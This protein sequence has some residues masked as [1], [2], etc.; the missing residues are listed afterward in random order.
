MAWATYQIIYWS[1]SKLEFMED[2]EEKEEELKR[3]E[4]EL[5]FALKEK[6]TEATAAAFGADIV[7]EG[8]G[9]SA[10]GRNWWNIF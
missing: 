6:K 10:K 8:L 9:K 7:P 4:R 1:W 5:E 2:K 3:L